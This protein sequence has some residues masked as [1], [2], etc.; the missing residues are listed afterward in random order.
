MLADV[1]GEFPRDAIASISAKPRSRITFNKFHVPP[2][3]VSD[4]ARIVVREARPI[5]TVFINMVPLLACHLACLATNTQCRVSQECGGPARL[6]SLEI[7][8]DAHAAS[9]F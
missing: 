2:R 9:I 4:R 7:G 3:R 8:R 5:E 1:G 6:S